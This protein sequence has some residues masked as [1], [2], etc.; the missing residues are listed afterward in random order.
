MNCTLYEGPDPVIIGLTTTF[1]F[2]LWGV[3][4]VQTAGPV[5]SFDSPTFLNTN[6][7][8]QASLLWDQALM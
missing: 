3:Y 8:T 6:N 2:N 5:G 4:S 7:H 1:V